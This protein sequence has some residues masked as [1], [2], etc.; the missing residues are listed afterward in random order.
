MSKK[1]FF[2]KSH[3]ILYNGLFFHSKLELKFALMIEDHCAYMREP[4]TINYRKS[5]LLPTEYYGD[6]CARYRP[7]FLVRK[8]HNGKATLIE[9]K[10]KSARVKVDVLE[11]SK[12]AQNYIRLKN[13][14]WEY[15]ILDETAIKLT[16][17]KQ[18]IYQKL[19][20]EYEENLSKIKYLKYINKHDPI[21]KKNLASR[22]PLFNE[23]GMTC[24]DYKKFL[25][26]KEL[27]C[28]ENSNLN[29]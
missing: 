10:N 1:P 15:K 3:Q 22:V 16:P 23:K 9:I 20:E 13:K 14:D 11:K 25:I 26:S 27:P 17:E 28:L 29:R 5:S 4:V 12:V 2:K 19:M 8:W 21:S 24:Q 6:G 18:A 7:D